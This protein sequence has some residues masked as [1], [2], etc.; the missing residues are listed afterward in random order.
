MYNKQILK[1]CV[2]V[3]KF[4]Y[5]KSFI[6]YYRSFCKPSDLTLKSSMCLY[7]L[8][9]YEDPKIETIKTTNYKQIFSF[10]AQFSLGCIFK[11][12]WLFQ[13]KVLYLNFLYFSDQTYFYY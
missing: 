6:D 8:H 10:L 7:L 11:A 13:N 12:D 9:I 3:K 4:S 5:T 2:K 1:D